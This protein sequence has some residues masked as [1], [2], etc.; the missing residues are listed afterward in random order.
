MSS[1]FKK[2]RVISLFLVVAMTFGLLCGTAISAN[3]EENVSNAGSQ[4]NSKVITT[5]EPAIFNVTVPYVLPISIDADQN[6]YVADNAALTNNS[7]GPIRVD[8]A[9]ITTKDGWELVGS[10]TDFKTVPVNS[11]KI[12]LDMM[13]EPVD[14]SGTVNAGLFSS[15]S[16]DS[17]LK[18]DYDANAAVQANALSNQNVA[19][20]LFTVEWDKYELTGDVINK[21]AL[22]TF[23]KNNSLKSFQRTSESLNIDDVETDGRMIKI[24]NASVAEASVKTLRSTR[25]LKSA[26]EDDKAVYAWTD[27]QGN[28]YWWSNA[29]KVYLPTDCSSLFAN[30]EFTTLDLSNLDASNVTNMSYM[31]QNC[32]NLQTLYLPQNYKESNV[33]DMSYAFD[34]CT[35]LTAAPEMPSC[36]ENMTRTFNYCTSLITAPEIPNSVTNMD[37]TFS[38]CH[39]LAAAPKIP[40]SVENMNSTFFACFSLTTAP[41]IPSSVTKMRET[42]YHCKS[43]TTVF[44][45]PGSVRDLSYTFYGCT[46]LVNAPKIMYGIENLFHTFDCCKSLTTAPEIPSSVT[47]MGSTFRSCTSLITAPKIPSSVTEFSETFQNC[48]SLSA[49][50]EIPEGVKNMVST[51]DCCFSLTTAPKIP[52]SVTTMFMTF[53][54]CESL[55]GKVTINAENL[56]IYS[57]CFS[58]TKNNIYLAGSCPVLS[59]IAGGYSNVYLDSES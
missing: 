19:D 39:S 41:E 13:G 37:S 9:V 12:T 6:V 11:K 51:F 55:T 59:D 20:V 32:K 47:K 21:T 49:A 22:N 40:N 34:F 4:G 27:E 26:V 15:V 53:Y 31:F 1:K 16:G 28:G 8:S 2:N 50:P 57:N 48:Y 29:D 10:S 25:E 52:S 54:N 30:C 18:I 42:F 24:D 3:A 56:S 23:V 14:V 36:T 58:G 45:I 46:S 38:G 7:N 44:E 17:S 43:L 35:S 33:K 5:I